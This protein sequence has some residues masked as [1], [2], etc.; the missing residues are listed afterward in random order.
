[1][2][3]RDAP[4]SAFLLRLKNALQRVPLLTEEKEGTP[5]KR[6]ERVPEMKLVLCTHLFCAVMRTS[7]IVIKESSRQWVETNMGR[8]SAFLILA[9][10][11]MDG[12]LTMFSIKFV[13]IYPLYSLQVR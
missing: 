8:F 13:C 5:K 1:M 7:F 6:Y 9:I 4:S 3:E 2:R 12:Y 11:V 10:F